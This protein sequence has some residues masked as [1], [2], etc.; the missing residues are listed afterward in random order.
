MR[1]IYLFVCLF[2]LQFSHA[3]KQIISG[4]GSEPDANAIDL[5]DSAVTT[6]KKS[7][8]E[9]ARSVTTLP[10]QFWWLT[11]SSDMESITQDMLS[12]LVQEANAAFD[13]A[14]LAFFQC[15]GLEIMIS[16]TFAEFSLS[17][18]SPL[19]TQHYIPG[20]VNLYI[21]NSISA[22]DG[23]PLCG[24]AK[25][26]GSS[27]MIFMDKDCLM[28]GSTLNHEIGHF[29]G[30]YHTHGISSANPTNELANGTN[31]TVAGDDV[32]DTPADPN[33]KDIVDNNCIYS[34]NESDQNGDPFNPDPTNLMCYAPA[35]CRNQFSPG[36][37]ER[38][39]YVHRYLR[40]YLACP[41]AELGLAITSGTDLCAR[42]I[43]ASGTYTGDAQGT[44]SWDIDNDDIIDYTGPSYSHQYSEPGD[45]HVTMY[46][47]DGI[48][49]YSVRRHNAVQLFAQLT[50]PV[51]YSFDRP[52]QFQYLIE[53]PDQ[54]GTWY[55]TR[56]GS[57]AEDYCLTIDNYHNY[58]RGEIDEITLP[59][60]QLN[61][62][63]FAFLTFDVAYAYH[64]LNHQDKL[65]VLVSSNCGNSYELLY[66]KSGTELATVEGTITTQWMPASSTDWRTETID[67]SSFLGEQVLI[68]FRNT[69][70][71]GN[72]VYIDEVAVDGDEVL[73]L[74]AFSLKGKKI[75]AGHN[76]LQWGITQ[77]EN[78][79]FTWLEAATEPEALRKIYDIPFDTDQAGSFD[80]RF[81]AGQSFYY[82]LA[83]TG[84]D[85]KTRFS[86]IIHIPGNSSSMVRLFPNPAGAETY[87]HLAHEVD[88]PVVMQLQIL[89]TGGRIY[90]RQAVSI[91]PGTAR[92]RVVLTD[93]PAGL[94]LL[95]LETEGAL[96]VKRFVKQ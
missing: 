71:F 44:I 11:D 15:S 68:K 16:E 18:E 28:D 93:L 62:Q 47:D 72:H 67:L 48:D 75:S 9:A 95:Q 58:Q 7:P 86:P 46:L 33:L 83:G 24:Y 79:S 32:C 57:Q 36:Q 77:S 74:E 3:Q 41:S 20:L 69:N 53:N 2:I 59:P 82:R 80:H 78:L 64:G 17:Q 26:P 52:G 40:S 81:P 60:I 14:H 8:R 13:G 84:Q 49:E 87:I 34:G 4:C 66:A 85:S 51:A 42:E 38:M 22:F 61:G 88:K 90:K 6:G 76:V 65:E 39:D 63:S 89:D 10:I 21:F 56:T 35:P 91:D 29:F 96:H 12:L 30:L 55:E 31:C 45:Y 23:T 27:D 94:Y 37:L 19:R 70:D 25:F 73:A 92:V 50:M 43:I 54:D 5:I 1:L